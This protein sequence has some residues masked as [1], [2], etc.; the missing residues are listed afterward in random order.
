M[1]KVTEDGLKSLGEPRE[2]SEEDLEFINDMFEEFENYQKPHL[3]Q[4]ER[5]LND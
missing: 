1:I 2:L 5:E 3:Y 4:P